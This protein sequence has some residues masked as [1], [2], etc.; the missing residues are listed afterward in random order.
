ML[1][2][3]NLQSMVGG[4]TTTILPPNNECTDRVTYG[5]SRMSPL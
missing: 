1:A 4:P 2:N 5:R 3:L